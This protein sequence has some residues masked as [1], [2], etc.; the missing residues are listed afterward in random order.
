VDVT[1]PVGISRRNAS[2]DLLH[3]FPNPAKESITI[4]R[5]KAGI[6][7]YKIFSVNGQLLHNGI[8]TESANTIDVSFLEKGMYFLT[9]SMQDLVVTRKF[10][11]Q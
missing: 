11:K 2:S 3:I 6:H 7:D 9:V 10:I 8:L 5:L 1:P 4:Q